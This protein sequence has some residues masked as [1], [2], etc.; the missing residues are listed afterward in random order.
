MSNFLA[1]ATPPAENRMTLFGKFKAALQ[2]V[3]IDL[4]AIVETHGFFLEQQKQD[5]ELRIPTY[6]AKIPAGGGRAFDIITG[7]DDLD[8]SIPSFR[9]VIATFHSSNALFEDGESGP[10]TNNPPICQSPDGVQGVHGNTGEITLCADCKHNQWGSDQKGGRGKDCKNMRRLYVLVEGS[11]IPIV[12]TMPPTSIRPW[13]AYK[14]SLAVQRKAPQDVVT[15]FSLT[16][17]KNAA[18]TAYSV[19][20]FKAAGLLSTEARLTVKALGSGE[21]YS[22]D[23]N[24]D[25][26][27]V[28]EP[29]V[30]D[31]GE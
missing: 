1:N 8:T 20:K 10:D 14:A 11:S 16:T 15:E 22:K 25:D 7:D 12:M 19:V 6:R 30:A 26:Y 13:E 18:G 29:Q 31:T 23:L 4:E 24:G 17:E 27:N 9:G 5:P 3:N 28:A 2:E 21:S